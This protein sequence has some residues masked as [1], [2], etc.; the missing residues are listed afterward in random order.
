MNLALII[1]VVQTEMAHDLLKQIKSGIYQPDQVVIIDNSAHGFIG[2]IH[3]TQ[4]IRPD[5]PPL[6]VNASWELGISH[7]RSDITIV[8][9]LNDDIVVTN[10]FLSKTMEVFDTQINCGV[11]IPRDST[12]EEVRNHNTASQLNRIHKTKKRSGWAFF[13]KRSV[14][15]KIPL[16][17]TQLTNF[18]GDAWF[19]D[20][21]LKEG[22]YRLHMVD[23]PVYH[24]GGVTLKQSPLRPLRLQRNR[25]RHIYR[26][27]LKEARTCPIQART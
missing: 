2:P 8:G 5:K 4:Q 16:I 10:C 24:Y 26:K 1:P 21:A 17:P 23:N 3:G 20:N 25:E 13:I 9:V 22:S 27:I 14:L 15:N 6:P 11:A 19:F 12:E 7:L 18:F